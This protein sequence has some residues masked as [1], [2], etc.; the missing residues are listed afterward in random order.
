MPHLTYAHLTYASYYLSLIL[1]VH[2]LLMTS[3]S[4]TLSV[5]R[6][7]QVGTSSSPLNSRIVLHFAVTDT[8]CGISKNEQTKLFLPYTRGGTAPTFTLSYLH[9]LFLVA[10]EIRVF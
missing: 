5:N 4:V 2:I 10:L 3:Y 6:L 9:A 8:G 1:L 7:S